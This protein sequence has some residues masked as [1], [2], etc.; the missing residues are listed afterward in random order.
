[1]IKKFFKNKYYSKGTWALILNRPMGENLART[2]AK[3]KILYYL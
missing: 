1:M 2:R 3:S